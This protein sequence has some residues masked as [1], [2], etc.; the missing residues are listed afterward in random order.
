MRSCLTFNILRG[1]E[2]IVLAAFFGFVPVLF[3]LLITLVTASVMFGTKALGPWTLWSFVPAVA[4]NVLLLKKWVKG[5][6]QMSGKALASVYLF[7]SIIGL[8]MC[9]GIPLVSFTL[10]IAAGLYAARRMQLAQA[11]EQTGKQ[12]FKKTAFFSAAVMAIMCCLITLWAIAGQ[13]IGYRIDT[14]TITAPIFLA[15]VLTGGIVAV[16]L[17]YFVTLAAAKLMLRFLSSFSS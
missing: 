5:A 6:Y 15:I 14:F 4:I 10:G 13:M 9:M 16:T 8:G 3:F 17:Q 7:Y 11:D 1:V 12:Y 2:C